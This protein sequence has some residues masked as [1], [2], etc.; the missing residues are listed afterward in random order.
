MAV[1]AVICSTLLAGCSQ[2]VS[3]PLVGPHGQEMGKT[4]TSS[5]PPSITRPPS[6][7]QVVSQ[8]VSGWLAAETAFGDAART[9]D[10]DAPELAATTIDPQLAWTR[11]LLERMDASGQIAKG[12]VHFGTPHVIALHGDEA[13]VRTCA[14]DAEIVIFAASGRA[15]PGILGQADYE[16]FTSAM[17]QTEG[18]WKLLTQEV[19]VG[20]CT[21]L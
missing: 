19:G 6:R 12:P 9:S 4:A 2:S 11:S 10:P 14:R 8:V 20:Q 17:R 5:A 1:A 18:G 13:T 15:A 3:P 21:R 16:L 7:S